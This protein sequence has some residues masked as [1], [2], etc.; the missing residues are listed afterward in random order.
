GGAR[1]KIAA[2]AVTRGEACV[3][4]IVRKNSGVIE[5]KVNGDGSSSLDVTYAGT[6]DMS[7][8][9]WDGDG[10]DY[11]DDTVLEF[12]SF[13]TELSFDDR[14]KV[15]E[16]LRTKW[17]IYEGSEFALTERSGHWELVPMTY[18]QNVANGSDAPMLQPGNSV[19]QVSMLGC[20]M[21]SI[22]TLLH[23]EAVLSPGTDLARAHDFA[24][25]WLQKTARWVAYHGFSSNAIDTIAG[26]SGCNRS[27]YKVAAYDR[28]LTTAEMDWNG[29]SGVVQSPDPTEPGPNNYLWFPNGT[30]SF[31]A[32]YMAAIWMATRFLTDEPD[33][34]DQAIGMLE[35]NLPAL[36]ASSPNTYGWGDLAYQSSQVD[37]W[38]W[39][40]PQLAGPYDSSIQ[41]GSAHY[42]SSSGYAAAAR[43]VRPGTAAYAGTSSY[44]AT[45]S[46]IGG[47]EPIGATAHYPGVSAYGATPR[48]VKK[49]AAA[50]AGVSDYDAIGSVSD[51]PINASAAYGGVSAYGAAAR[52][53]KKATAGYA[54]TSAYAATGTVRGPRTFGVTAHY[55][56]VSAYVG[57]AVLREPQF[58]TAHYP[59]MSSYDATGIVEDVVEVP[60]W[61]QR[62]RNAF[63]RLCR[64]RGRRITY[65][66][67]G[68]AA[69]ARFF[70]A[71]IDYHGEY[72]DGEVLHKVE[73]VVI[74][75]PKHASATLTIEKNDKVEVPMRS[76]GGTK[77]S[78]V[79]DIIA[80]D[81]EKFVV[82]V[83]N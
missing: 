5:V 63:L 13:T 51:G 53:V 59:G 82:E 46:V 24:L 25:Q 1:T 57:G 36:L 70:D 9:G 78:R 68:G 38:L 72:F 14:R 29:N 33:T 19:F 7:G 2:A 32:Q 21:H 75:I 15:R 34:V 54:G 8:F 20:V 52:V 27:V 79:N 43:V 22:Y 49:A 76:G 16:F 56:G 6:F 39:I 37:P 12:G 4:E 60:D 65:R 30:W 71:I 64:R 35:R 81:D 61:I 40:V 18:P 28:L 58:V 83:E 11:F 62:L 23:D 48:V 80:Q 10:T 74:H 41:I 73:G 3:L 55:P 67:N 42:S 17:D 69:A 26:I 66:G 50:Y 44:A 77:L 31:C 45:A 47:G